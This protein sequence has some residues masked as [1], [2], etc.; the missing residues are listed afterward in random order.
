[1]YIL[2]IHNCYDSGAVL[3]KDGECIF[4][5]NEERLSRIKL[6]GEF[7]NKA[8]QACLDFAGIS[9]NE[10]DVV[11]YAWH[12]RFPYEEH[13]HDYVK[14]ALEIAEGG[15]EAKRIMLERIKIE[16]ERSVPRREQFEK[17]A[18]EK[19]V[20]QKVEFYD[21]HHAHA[22]SAY[23]TSPFD[24]A[25]VFTL[26]AAGSF[27][28]GTVSI[29][30][31]NK[32]EEISCNY[33][34][35]SL[36]FFYGQ[37]TDMLG[38]KPHRHEGKITGL[39]A[40]GNP[41]KCLPIMREMIYAK[42]GKVCAKVG[43]YYK[44]FFW[45]QTDELK[46]VLREFTREDIAAAVQRH[47][48]E[49][50]SQYVKYYV[51]K[52]GINKVACAGG[53]FANVRVNQCVRE[54]PGVDD[55]YIFP[56]MGDGGLSAGACLLSAVKRD[57]GRWRV[58]QVYLGNEESDEKIKVEVN[59]YND[60]I[61]LTEYSHS[62][63][64]NKVIELLK[65]NTVVGLFQGRMEYGPRALG[66]RTVL[67]H[68]NDKGANDWLNKRLKRTEFMPFA[69]VTTK[70]IA[71]RCFVGWKPNH[72]TTNFMTEC[73]NCTEEMKL[74]SPA[75]VHVDGTARP[76]IVG[77][78]DNPFY[79]DIISSWYKETGGLCLINTSF[80]QHEEPIVCTVEDAIESLLGDN[81]DCVVVNGKYII[82]KV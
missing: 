77:R 72:I 68:C 79:Y 65:N 37:I 56:H 30:K 60:S 59:K 18:K 9:L 17:W 22:A 61:Q 16:V 28:S 24:E 12:Y 62:D 74:N 78:D 55:L 26:D 7:P 51:D 81:V 15:E 1:M 54:V 13:L 50:I 23:Y 6:D 8:I 53:I 41:A 45:Q 76:Q 69:P 25:L 38:F 80:N 48:E 36:G 2:G 11:S 20:T 3:F 44:P 58:K 19:G 31:G 10:V 63:L 47:T 66:N 70:E 27:R 32:L 21:H 39:A 29:G 35:D 40:H 57:L 64:V 82:R 46:V 4:A 34:W 14:R 67:Y 33:T 71:P 43:K 73:Y 42:D 5:I 75:V 49:V 52:F